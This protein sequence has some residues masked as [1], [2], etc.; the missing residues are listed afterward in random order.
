MSQ[1]VE[2]LFTALGTELHP[3]AIVRSSTFRG[4]RDRQRPPNKSTGS[5]ALVLL[6]VRYSGDII[7]NNRGRPY[8]CQI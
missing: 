1:L 4:E 3:R 8:E 6:S 5:S 2:T 7:Q